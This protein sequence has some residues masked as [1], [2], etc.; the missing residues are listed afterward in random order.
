MLIIGRILRPGRH[1]LAALAMTA[2]MLGPMAMPGIPVSPVPFT[3]AEHFPIPG[4]SLFHDPRQHAISLCY[5]VPI[6]GEA[7]PQEDALELTWFDV[8]DLASSGVLDELELGQD[9]I[10]RRALAHAGVL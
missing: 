1:G 6:R 8:T 9:I 5:I 7:A 4:Q 10:V 2:A 3:V